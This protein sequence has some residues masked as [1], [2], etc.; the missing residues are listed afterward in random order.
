M[1]SINTPYGCH[2]NY[3]AILSSPGVIA[4]FSLPLF[5][6]QRQVITLLINYLYCHFNRSFISISV[7]MIFFSEFL[8]F[9]RIRWKSSLQKSRPTLTT[10]RTREY[11]ATS[12]HNVAIN[13][14]ILIL[15]QCSADVKHIFVFG[16]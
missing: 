3:S 12:W 2:V 13:T 11:G 7:N 14:G 8:S 5:Y 9:H 16:K 1:K 4:L 15:R 6:R 10:S